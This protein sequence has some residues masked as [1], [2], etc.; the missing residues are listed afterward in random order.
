[1]KTC[2]K[3][4]D[5]MNSENEFI[6]DELLLQLAAKYDGIE[7]LMTVRVSSVFFR[8]SPRESSGSSAERQTCSMYLMIRMKERVFVKG[9]PNV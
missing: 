8:I 3:N 9:K 7:S 1:M 4:P 5:H 2:Q 6:A